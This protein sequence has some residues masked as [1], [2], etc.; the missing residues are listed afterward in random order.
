MFLFLFTKVHSLFISNAFFI[1]LKTIWLKA[2]ELFDIFVVI[3]FFFTQVLYSRKFPNHHVQNTC[4]NKSSLTFAATEPIIGTSIA[5]AT[6][7][8]PQLNATTLLLP[9][10]IRRNFLENYIFRKKNEKK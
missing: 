2:S 4:N 3:F 8:M 10:P 6:A 1:S 7:A 5:G 9:R